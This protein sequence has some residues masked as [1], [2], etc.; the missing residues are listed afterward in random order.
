MIVPC[1]TLKNGSKVCHD[2]NNTN[3]HFSPMLKST[4]VVLLH[5]THLSLLGCRRSPEFAAALHA[6][7]PSCEAATKLWF[8]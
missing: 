7:H 1:I 6:V 3:K 8:S 4:V 5:S 2:L